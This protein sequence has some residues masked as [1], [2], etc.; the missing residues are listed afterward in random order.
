VNGR[1]Q[2]AD[3]FPAEELLQDFNIGRFFVTPH[4]PNDAVSKY[5]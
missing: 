5:P 3:G 4:P 2:G 1:K